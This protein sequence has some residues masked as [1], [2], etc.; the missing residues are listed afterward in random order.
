[1]S[2]RPE[3]LSGYF[4]LDDPQQAEASARA[5]AEAEALKTQRALPEALREPAA[6]ALIWALKNLLDDPISETIV[7]A[8]TKLRELRK[9]ADAPA[10]EL[11]E[12]TLHEH[13]I[14]LARK[15]AIELVLNGTPTGLKIEFEMKLGLV[16][17]S[18]LIKVQGRRIVGAR[19]GDVLGSGSISCGKI[20]IAERN[21]SKVALPGELAFRPGVAIP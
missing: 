4:K 5:L 13:D 1:M 9:F 15:P 14:S 19:I 2:A 10:D 17:Q 8:W 20:T 16:M 7:K 21:T 12:L 6:K 18:A 3:T 11:N